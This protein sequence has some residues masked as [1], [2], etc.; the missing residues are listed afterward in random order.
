[1]VHE[2]GKAGRLGSRETLKTQTVDIGIA[3][4]NNQLPGWWNGVFGSL[5]ADAQRGIEIR[6]ILSISSAL[7]DHNKNNTVGVLAWQAEQKDRM[8]RTDVN[9]NEISKRFM[10]GGSDGPADWLFM[11][12]DDTVPPH[13]TLS[14]LLGLDKDFVA[15]LYFNSNPPYNPIAYMRNREGFGY[16][17][18][19]DY[20]HGALTQVDSVGMGC[21][22]IHRSVFERIIDGHSVFSRP[23]GS[24]YPVHKSKIIDNKIKGLDAHGEEYVSGGYLVTKL[25][26]LEE[27]DNRTWP[28][29][30]MEY[31]RTEDH[32]FCELAENVGI[33][34]WIDTRIHCDHIKT[35]AMTYERYR[36]A[37]NERNGLV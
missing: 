25:D 11:I 2:P 33:K 37:V 13:G 14:H 24:L 10:S 16:Y 31:G 35:K 21:T 9:R 34:P 12:D 28:F 17:A 15:G 30:S 22:L 32:H 27:G 36:E 19:Y 20:P 23:N 5:L 3:C 8:K 18:L 29:Y 26:K 6:Q 7:P 4:S 1:L